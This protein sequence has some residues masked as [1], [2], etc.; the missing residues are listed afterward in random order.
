LTRKAHQDKTLAQRRLDEQSK[1]DPV[2]G[3]SRN[4]KGQ[5]S[6]KAQDEAWNKSLLK[7]VILDRET[8][9]STPAPTA[10]EPYKP[11]HLNFK[12]NEGD[13]EMLSDTLPAVASL[14]TLLGVPLSNASIADRR[15]AQSEVIEADKREKLMRIIDL[16]NA[17]SK[18]IDV[19]NKRR[20]ARAFSVDGQTETDTG[21][22]EVQGA[23]AFTHKGT[24]SPLTL[25]SPRF[26][27]VRPVLTFTCLSP[28]T[29]CHLDL[30]HPFIVEPPGLDA[31][32][33]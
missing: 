18:G 5:F 29:S 9:W 23:C 33:H 14:R 32:R 13:L 25:K 6:A 24:C 26:M 11:S 31:S 28:R 2:L 30:S 4:Q 12:L 22:P 21:R 20:I 27:H 8:I 7:Q 10:G 16:R 15:A 1:P 17:D 19:E 3:Y